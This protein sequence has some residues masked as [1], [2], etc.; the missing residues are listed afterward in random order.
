MTNYLSSFVLVINLLFF[1]ISLLTGIIFFSSIALILL[2]IGGLTLII[3]SHIKRRD[4]F[5]GGYFRWVYSL[6]AFSTILLIYSIFIKSLLLAIFS[7]L[8]GG[9]YLIILF[10]RLSEEKNGT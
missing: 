3:T 6:L 1:S 4:I 10:A 9:I 8:G 7:F 2:S 5:G